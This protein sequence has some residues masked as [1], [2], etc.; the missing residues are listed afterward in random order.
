MSTYYCGD[1]INGEYQFTFGGN[2]CE[3][4]GFLMPYSGRIKRI[5]VR[6]IGVFFGETEEGEDKLLIGYPELSFEEALK[7]G[8]FLTGNLFSIILF[9]G[10]INP[11]PNSNPIGSYFEDDYISSNSVGSII[12]TYKCTIVE[13]IDDTLKENVILIS[14]II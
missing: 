4:S 8:S 14:I 3:K 6:L 10:S 9:K 5:K 11:N 13:S 2:K 1:L 7:D 12:S